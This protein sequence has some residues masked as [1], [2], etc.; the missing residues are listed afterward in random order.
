MSLQILVGIPMACQAIRV[1]LIMCSCQNE[2]DLVVISSTLALIA[3][4]RAEELY[5][6]KINGVLPKGEPVVSSPSPKS[7][8][9]TTAC[10]EDIFKPTLPLR[11][12]QFDI[13][14][15]GLQSFAHEFRFATRAKLELWWPPI[16]KGKKGCERKL[17]G[18]NRVDE[19]GGFLPTN[20]PS[21]LL[22]SQ[23]AKWMTRCPYPS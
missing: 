7:H 13:G 18:R 17:K 5:E 16:L 3:L 12:T 10:L 1:L 6:G 14:L 9:L 23:E 22:I 21:K 8:I 4:E 2:I 15:E 19:W 20:I 11:A